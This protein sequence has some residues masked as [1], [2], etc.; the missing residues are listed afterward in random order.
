MK[1]K[2]K[3]Y[4]VKLTVGENKFFKEGKKKKKKEKY[5]VNLGNEEK[6]CRVEDRL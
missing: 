5:K 6:P 3:E 4:K 1:K 2:R